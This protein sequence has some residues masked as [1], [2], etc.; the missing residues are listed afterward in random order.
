LLPYKPFGSKKGTHAG[1][2][3]WE[4]CDPV[5]SG[6][7]VTKDGWSG[8]R[9]EADDKSREILVQLIALVPVLL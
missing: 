4:A 5:S 8:F 1:L 7:I 2:I 3:G 9:R 6:R